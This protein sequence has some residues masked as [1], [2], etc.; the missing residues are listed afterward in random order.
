MGRIAKGTTLRNTRPAPKPTRRSSIGAWTVGK[1]EA[2]TDMAGRNITDLAT[3]L[4]EQVAAAQAELKAL[5][6]KVAN[7]RRIEAEQRVR[8]EAATAWLAKHEP[9]IEKAKKAL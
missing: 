3:Q 5:E 8:T 4:S 1:P 7:L 9:G 2:G 6:I